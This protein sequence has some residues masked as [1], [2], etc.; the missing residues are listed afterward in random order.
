MYAKEVCTISAEIA[1][2][3]IYSHFEKQHKGHVSLQS[4]VRRFSEAERDHKQP[5]LKISG[6]NHE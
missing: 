3:Q 6:D 2:S 1:A 4:G 5:D